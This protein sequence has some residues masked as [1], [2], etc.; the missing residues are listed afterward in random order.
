MSAYLGVSVVLAGA[1][2]LFLILFLFTKYASAA[3]RFTAVCRISI[4]LVPSLMFLAMLLNNELLA[5][6]G[7]KT[8]DENSR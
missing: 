3:V 6:Y 5:Q 7:K 8:V 4:Q 1:V 2:G